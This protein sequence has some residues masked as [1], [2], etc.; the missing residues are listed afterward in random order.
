[1]LQN[2]L[3]TY[4]LDMRSNNEFLFTTGITGLAQKM[5]E[6]KKDRIYPL[7]YNLLRVTLTLSIT[8]ASVE[9]AFSAMNI[10][11]NKLRNKMGVNCNRLLIL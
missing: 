9:R 7:A 8:T 11:K 2:Q 3:E 4:I 6:G 10:V 1:M 5:M